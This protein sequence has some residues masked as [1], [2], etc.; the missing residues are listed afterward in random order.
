MKIGSSFVLFIAL[1]AASTLG[2]AALDAAAQDSKGNN[3]SA[4]SAEDLRQSYSKYRLKNLNC[5]LE[6]DSSKRI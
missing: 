2:A 1:V 5:R 6:R 3:N 4:Q